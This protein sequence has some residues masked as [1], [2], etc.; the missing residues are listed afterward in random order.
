MTTPSAG[1]VLGA[2]GV[3]RV[4]DLPSLAGLQP[5]RLD[6]T[7][8]VGV[9]PRGPVGRPVRVDRFVDYQRRFGGFEGYS[10][11]PYAVRAFFAQGGQRAWVVRVAPPVLD[12]EAVARHRLTLGKDAV[13]ELAAR[14]EGSWGDGLS[15]GAVARFATQVTVDVTVSDGDAGIDRTEVFTGLGLDPGHP[16]FL[17]QVLHD[18][19]TLVAPTGEWATTPLVPADELPACVASERIACGRDRWSDIVAE[20]FFDDQDARDPTEDWVDV[21]DPSDPDQPPAHR[22]VDA[23]SLVDE[24]GLLVV[25]DLLWSFQAPVGST[26]T[27]EPPRRRGFHR[28]EPDPAPTFYPPG[29]VPLTQLDPLDADDLEEVGRRQTRLAE[30]A[31]DAR[32]F[33]ALLDVPPRLPVAAI[34]RWRALFDTPYDTSYAAAYHPWPGVARPDDPQRRTVLVPPSAFAAGI[35]ATREHRYGISWGGAN[36]LAADAVVADVVTDA[37]HAALHPLGV[38]IFRVERDGVRL[39]AARTLSRDPDYR[40]LSV[41]RLMTTLALTLERELRDLVFEPNTPALRLMVRDALVELLRGLDRTGAFAGA[42][43]A[44]SFFVTCDDGLNPPQSQGLG[45]LIAE[46]GV[47]PSQPL[48]YLVLRLAQDTDG[49]LRAEER[50]G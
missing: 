44:E 39:S 5:V 27:T 38:N 15:V 49:D 13:L 45:R 22:G 6:V 36:E 48:E 37:E 26:E 4:P 17:P 31:A 40:Q 46:I 7:A 42:T 33:V 10:L 34:V 2:P 20:S 16:R 32:R 30:R 28:C 14:D 11:L 41:R 9:A 1:L 24:V 12:P 18:A 19:S 47:A 43:E 23:A 3:Y 35:L 25:P 8:F 21:T 50:G 29:P